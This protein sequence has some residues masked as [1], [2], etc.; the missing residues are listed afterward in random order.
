MKYFNGFRAVYK[1][2]IIGLLSLLF[3]TLVLLFPVKQVWPQN[4][5]GSVEPFLRLEKPK[6]LLGEAIRFW[7]GVNVKN[8]SATSREAMKPCTLSIGKP[9][10][11]TETQSVGLGREGLTGDEY[12][13]YGGWGFG[14]AEVETGTYI[15]VLQCASEKTKPV[16]LVVEKNDIF[17]QIK[18]DFRFERSGAI[19]KGESVPI[20]LSVQNDSKYRIRFPQRGSMGEGVGIEVHRQEPAM[21]SAFFYPSDKLART[22]SMPDTYSWDSAPDIASITLGPGEHFEQR[23]TLE[24]AYTFDQPADYEVT[25]STVLAV[26]VGEKNDPFAE[27]CPIRLAVIGKA[28]F[29]PAN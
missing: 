9:D 24:D 6:Y 4:V 5:A 13:S 29:A 20:I 21:S 22:T 19:T 12:S 16:E 28:V 8:S 18:A 23:F 25:F 15:L 11:T 3:F 1:G 10:G 2:P 14:E 27:Y 7:V 17:D 26:L